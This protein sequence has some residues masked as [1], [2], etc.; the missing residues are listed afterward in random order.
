[1]LRSAAASQKLVSRSLRS[2]T[3]PSC[4]RYAGCCIR[5]FATTGGPSGSTASKTAEGSSTS[6]VKSQPTSPS[7]TST[8]SPTPA[9]SQPSSSASPQTHTRVYGGLKDADR[10][11]TNIYGERDCFIKGALKRGDWHRTGDFLGMGRDW[12]INEVKASGLRGRGG[13]GFPSGLKWS[14]RDTLQCAAS[15]RKTAA[16]RL[17]P[18]LPLSLLAVSATLCQVVHAQAVCGRPAVLCG[19]QR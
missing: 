8:S 6:Q 9:P 15:T 19:D 13:A 3:V 14:L 1:M 7:S 2:A 4:H 10:I 18:Q 17:T 5:S 11:F 16:S 12:I